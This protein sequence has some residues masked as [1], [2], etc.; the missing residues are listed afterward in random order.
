MKL[1]IVSWNVRDLND[2]RKRLVVRN[3][4]REWNCDVV[5][6]QETK[7]AG[8]DRQL[9]CSLWSCPYVDWVA[10]DADQTAGGVLMMWDRRAL[11]KLEVMV[12][13]FF[14]S[15]RWQGMG[16]GFILACSGVYGPNDNN[17]KEQMW[18]ELIEIQ[19]LWEVPWCYIGDFNIIRFSSERLG[20][21]RLT[22]AMENFSK[23]I[24]ELSTPSFAL[25][26]K[27]KALKEDIIQWNHSEF[28]NVVRQKKELLETLKSLD[29]KEGE[30]GL[31][32]VEIEGLERDWL[33]RRFKK[34][35]VLRVVKEL[36]GDKAPGPDGFSMAFYHHCSGVVK[37]D[38]LTVFEV[39][40]QHS[41]FEKSLNATFM[42][43]IPKKNDVSNI[44]DFRPI[45]LVGS[46]YKIL[47]KVLVNSL[48]EVLDQLIFESQ[49]TLWVGIETRE[50]AI[51]HAVSGTDGDEEQ[52]LH[53]RMLLLCFQAVTRLK[54]NALK[55]E[56]VLIGEVPNVHVLVE[57]LG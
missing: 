32:E 15:V 13:Q 21:F 12:G 47:A 11:E 28:G 9:I 42:A 39:F 55:S 40:Y 56:M 44:R 7:L 37:R 14:V 57:I 36:E 4:L 1:K 53:V 8:M 46:V 10:L 43:L 5:F 23:F 54:V 38:V 24:E 35:E 6:L 52:I 31:F 30:N 22:L 19:Q 16:D 3:L 26:K 2:S 18:D 29:A 48:K 25:A 49:I 50:L 51:S 34:E 33:E 20:G 41:K 17:V 27:L 45:S